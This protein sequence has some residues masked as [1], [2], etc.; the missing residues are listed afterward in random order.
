MTVEA[1]SPWGPE[2]SNFLGRGSL[3]PLASG[4]LGLMLLT[5]SEETVRKINDLTDQVL[6]KAA[7]DGPSHSVSANISTAF[8]GLT[9]HCSRLS[10]RVAEVRLIEHCKSGRYVQKADTWFWDR[11]DARRITYVCKKTGGRV[12]IR[13]RYGAPVC[14][15]EGEA[16]EYERGRQGATQSALSVCKRQEV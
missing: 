10:H 12:A 7:A 15:L 8:C 4:D 2:P 3:P 11:A 1:T 9:I 5:L 6:K 16:T 14:G 13:S